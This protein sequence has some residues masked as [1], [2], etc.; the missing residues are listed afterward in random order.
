M[1]KAS[2]T[3]ESFDRNEEIKSSSNRSLGIVFCVAFIVIGLIPLLHGEHIRIWCFIVAGVFL[4]LGLVF[5]VVLGPLNKLWT[6]LGLLLHAVVSPLVLGLMF[7]FIFTPIGF[8][9][10]LFGKDLLRLRCQKQSA[11]YWIRRPTQDDR[12]VSESMKNQF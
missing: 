5:P 8:L 3:F 12:P 2:Q 1:K 6:K 4:F 10:R 9:I 7:F 11:S